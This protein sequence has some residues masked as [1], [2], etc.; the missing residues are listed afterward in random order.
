MDRLTGLADTGELMAIE[1][2]LDRMARATGGARCYGL[3]LVDIT[4][5]RKINARHGPAVGDAVLVE[6]A[7]RLA[8]M[9]PDA[10]VARVGGD[11]FAVLEDGLDAHEMS[12]LC[13]EMSLVVNLQPFKIDELSIKVHVT[14]NWRCGPDSNFGST[15]LLW[16]VQRDYQVEMKRNFDH[17]LKALEKMAL[18]SLLAEQADAETRLLRAEQQAQHDQ[19]TGLLNRWG[20][21]ALLPTVVAPY[22][23]AFVDVDKL[24]DLN[25]AQGNWA[26]GDQAL[27]GVARLLENLSPSAVV[28]R[29][30]GDEFLVLLP[31][32][33]ASKARAELESLL[34]R[35]ELHLRVGDLPVT[36]SA[37]V[38]YAVSK[39]DHPSAFE[40][41]QQTAQ[42]VKE[43]GRSQIWI[44]R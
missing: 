5:L 35:P 27:R 22:A 37:G 9:R 1:A 4:G 36:F 16:A 6:L 31:G 15:Q 44:A 18:T 2:H 25:K 11:E 26:A 42:D 28:V 29:W 38:A 14:N 39:A 30:S 12:R 7:D 13:R 19:L 20:Y 32:F 34:K 41:A 21:E 10:C 3:V 23:L 24:R 8:G 40:R 33:T 43:A 17:R